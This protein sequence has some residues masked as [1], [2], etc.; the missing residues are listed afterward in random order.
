MDL[1]EILLV[2]GSG[3]A[4]ALAGGV[5]ALRGWLD[6]RRRRPGDPPSG[7]PPGPPFGDDDWDDDE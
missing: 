2:L 6:R 7:T 4:L 1:N 3:V 5:A